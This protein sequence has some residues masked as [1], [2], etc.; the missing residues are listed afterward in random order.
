MYGG[1]VGSRTRVQKKPKITSFTRLVG[2]LL[3]Q[4]LSCLRVPPILLNRKTSSRL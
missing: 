3:Q 4:A 1:G 2:F